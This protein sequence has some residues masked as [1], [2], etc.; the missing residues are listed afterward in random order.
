MPWDWIPGVCLSTKCI[1]PI[2]WRNESGKGVNLFLAPPPK[3]SVNYIFPLAFNLLIYSGKKEEGKEKKKE[4]KKKKEKENRNNPASR[5]TCIEETQGTSL[6]ETI[7]NTQRE[8]KWNDS[9]A[10]GEE[11]NYP[12]LVEVEKLTVRL[13]REKICLGTIRF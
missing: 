7:S 6:L 5:T 1:I 8:I 9:A 3:G 4:K 13:E 12:R 2:E 11:K 10:T